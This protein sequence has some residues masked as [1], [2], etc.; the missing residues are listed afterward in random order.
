MS[1]DIVRYS[2][3]KYYSK[4]HK[5]YIKLDEVLML[6]KEGEMVEVHDSVSKRDITRDTL[7]KVLAHDKNVTPYGIKQLIYQSSAV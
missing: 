3:R 2:N 5:R 1:V 4:T 6:I 7:I